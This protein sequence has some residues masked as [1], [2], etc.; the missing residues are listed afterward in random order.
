[1]NTHKFI[2]SFQMIIIVLILFSGRTSLGLFESIPIYLSIYG[3]G[4]LILFMLILQKKEYVISAPVYSSLLFIFSIV[5]MLGNYLTASEYGYNKTIEFVIYVFILSI[6]I[7]NCLETKIDIINLIKSFY[8]VSIVISI[9]SITVGLLTNTLTTERLTFLGSGPNTF[10][11]MI[12]YGLIANIFLVFASK[13][14]VFKFISIWI[15]L[16][17]ILFSG[18]RQTILGSI[19]FIIFYLLIVIIVQKKIDKSRLLRLFSLLMILIVPIIFF[20]TVIQENKYFQRFLLLFS[21]EKGDSFNIRT[22][23]LEQ[24]ILKGKESILFGNGTGAFELKYPEYIYPHNVFAEIFMENGLVGLLILILII[25]YPLKI[26]IKKYKLVLKEI[27]VHQIT[28]LV[29][30]YLFTVYTAQISGDLFDNR[31]IFL[32]G[33]I[34]LKYNFLFSKSIY[35]EFRKGD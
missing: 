4:I 29:V 30:M 15:F 3:M 23:L 28:A 25:M 18:A 7:D 6:I 27:D 24:A 1:M 14:S 13:R 2:K 32:I 8:Y 10:S 34:M 31:W 35:G 9:I 17:A 22:W 19:I 20:W 16:T 33:L 11:R 26:L 5:L 12:F 21:D